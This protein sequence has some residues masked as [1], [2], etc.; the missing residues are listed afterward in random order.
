VNFEV[1]SSNLGDRKGQRFFGAK[2][3]F[4]RILVAGILAAAV[5]SICAHETGFRSQDTRNWPETRGPVTWRFGEPA[6][7]RITSRQNRF[8]ETMGSRPEENCF[9]AAQ[10]ISGQK[11]SHFCHPSDSCVWGGKQPDRTRAGQ[12]GGNCPRIPASLPQ[13]TSEC[14]R[15]VAQTGS[16]VGTIEA[17]LGKVHPQNRGFVQ[18]QTVGIIVLGISCPNSAFANER[19]DA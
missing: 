16:G 11:G 3:W 5:L 1:R 7:H 19:R 9:P 10:P 14:P 12:E 17:E 2:G 13:W 18:N 8:A 6:D 15:L 4:S